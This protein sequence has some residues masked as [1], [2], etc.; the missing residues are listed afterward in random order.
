MLALLKEGFKRKVLFTI[1]TS[2]TTG[3]SNCVIWNGVH[4]KTSTTGGKERERL[5][6]GG[7]YYGYPDDTYFNRVKEEL[8]AKGIYAD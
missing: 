1:G 2:V 7:A 6:I 3:M 4:H 5:M 8:A